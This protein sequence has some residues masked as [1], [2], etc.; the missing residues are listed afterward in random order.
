[1]FCYTGGSDKSDAI[2]GVP[3]QLL[4]GAAMVFTVGLHSRHVDFLL[5]YTDVQSTMIAN[6]EAIVCNNWTSCLN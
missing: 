6:F 1:M 2:E 5:I 4:K 3:D